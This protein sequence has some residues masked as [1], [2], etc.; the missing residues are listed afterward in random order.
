MTGVLP[1]PGSAGGA[2]P[3]PFAS[4]A[5]TPETRPPETTSPPVPPEPWLAAGAVLAVK[6]PLAAEGPWQ[7]SELAEYDAS[8]ELKGQ[9]TVTLGQPLAG[10][11]RCR[12]LA[13]PLS[14]FSVVVDVTLRNANSCAGLWLRFEGASGYALRV[15][16]DRYELMTHTDTQLRLLRTF[17]LAPVR[18]DAPVR[19]AVK[20]TGPRLSVFRDE[21][22]AGEITDT[23]FAGGRLI[24]GVFAV[25][26][27]AEP[28]FVVT[29]SNIELWRGPE[30]PR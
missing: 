19:V 26:E 29:F 23:T 3:Q 11:Y 5:T 25:D 18:V 12:G 16:R 14:D 2:T 21:V 28:P 10:S 24:L 27:R 30:P 17:F 15:C 1:L 4:P 6:D 8:C 9:L 20:A 13:D 22:L 7:S